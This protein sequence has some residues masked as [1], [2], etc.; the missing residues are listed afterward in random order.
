MEL[1]DVRARGTSICSGHGSLEVDFSR[2][3]H[4]RL[5]HQTVDI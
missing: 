3:S 2:A 5:W 1:E 4:V